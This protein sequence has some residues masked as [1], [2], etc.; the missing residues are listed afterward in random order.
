MARRILEHDTQVFH[1]V[2]GKPQ[3]ALIGQDMGQ[4]IEHGGR[5]KTAFVMTLL[6]P[7][8]GEENEHPLDRG[9]GERLDQQTRIVHEK[10]HI[11]E[12]P[13]PHLRQQLRNAVLEDLAADETAA[14]LRS[15]LRSQMLAGTESKLEPDRF[16]WRVEQSAGLEPSDFRQVEAQIG[17]QRRQDLALSG[18]QLAAAAAA[19]EDPLAG[20]VRIGGLRPQNAALSSFTRSSRSQEKPPSA[21]GV[22][23]KWP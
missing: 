1:I 20:C 13:P 12:T 6:R 3:L 9:F 18:P 10:P 14:R 4:G 7:G 16:D 17:K 2:G 21:S 11:D 22:R 5:D 8:I 15:G 19:I 23:P